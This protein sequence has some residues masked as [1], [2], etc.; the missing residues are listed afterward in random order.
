VA[1]KVGSKGSSKFSCFEQAVKIGVSR[2]KKRKGL[3][4]ES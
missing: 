1:T 4:L 3:I 2:I